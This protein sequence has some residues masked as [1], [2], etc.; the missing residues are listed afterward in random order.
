MIS[1]VMTI[2]QSRCVHITMVVSRS[3]FGPLELSSDNLVQFAQTLRQ[4]VL[5]SLPAGQNQVIKDEKEEK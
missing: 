4:H 2:S 1:Y 5:V 3:S